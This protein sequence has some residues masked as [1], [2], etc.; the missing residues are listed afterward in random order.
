MGRA[1]KPLFI[2]QISSLEFIFEGEEDK[3][4]VKEQTLN[5]FKVDTKSITLKA[6]KFGMTPKEF[7]VSS[8]NP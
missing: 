7:R 4:F 2:N 5:M 8:Q 1:P 3:K 6:I